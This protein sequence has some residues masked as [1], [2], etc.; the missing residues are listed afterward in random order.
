MVGDVWSTD[1]TTRRPLSRV[2]FWTSSLRGAGEGIVV[3]AAE[4]G[5]AVLPVVVAA[6]AGWG[7]GGGGVGG[8][9]AAPS[10]AISAKAAVRGRAWRARMPRALSRVGARRHSGLLEP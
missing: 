4:G 8:A 5:G 2:T 10:A 7:A 6:V 1:M 3:A 9:V